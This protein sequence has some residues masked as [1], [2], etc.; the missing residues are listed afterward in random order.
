M[1]GLQSVTG[2]F[3]KLPIPRYPIL[4][5]FLLPGLLGAAIIKL[6]GFVDIPLIEGTWQMTIS[7]FLETVFIGICIALLQNIIYEIYEGRQTTMIW[8]TTLVTFLIRRQQASVRTLYDRSEQ[9]KAKLS[10]FKDPGSPEYL[11]TQS[12]YEEYWQKL[13]KYPLDDTGNPT[14]TSPT[15]LGNILESYESYPESRYGMDAIFYWPRLWLILEQNTKDE[16]DSKWSTADGLLAL[17]F[18]SIVGFVLSFLEMILKFLALCSP[19]IVDLLRSLVL[20][21]VWTDISF[22]SV[23]L[24]MALE[25][26]SFFFFYRLSLPFHVENGEI[27]KSLFDMFRN[28]LEANFILATPKRSSSK[29]DMRGRVAKEKKKWRELWAYLQYKMLMCPHC[30][31]YYREQEGQKICPN[32]KKHF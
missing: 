28:K 13:R 5:R 24:L 4:I 2:I 14:A 20:M 29:T 21:K 15:L 26:I 11:E 10:E 16:I 17:S 8:S 31:D 27:F 9:T 12:R 6:N 30:K 25:L 3:E 1:S 23:A 19:P 18:V 7:L 22:T 32:C